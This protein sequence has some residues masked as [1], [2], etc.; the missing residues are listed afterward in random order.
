MCG[1]EQDKRKKLLNVT[2]QL[3]A[4][5]GKLREVSEMFLQDSISHMFENCRNI[6]DP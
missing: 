1:V 5:K 2:K 3:D 6:G 4:L